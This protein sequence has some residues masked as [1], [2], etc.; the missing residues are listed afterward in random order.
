ME[1]K[2]V[3]V[4]MSG[5]VDSSVAVAVLKE[6]G[7]DVSGVFMQGWTNPNFECNWLSER[8]DA[9]RVAAVL[10]IPFRVLDYSREYYERVVSYLISEYKTGRTPNPDVMCNREIKFGLFYKWA[11]EQGA[12]YVAT[13]HYVRRDGEKLFIAKD[14]NKDQSYFLWTLTPEI[15]S[16]TLFPI[17]E[18]TKPKVRALARKYGL[19]TAEKKDSQGICFVGEGNIA[20]F[21]KDH[22]HATRGLIETAS[23]R[24]VGEHDG[25]EFYTIGQ[26]HGIGARGKNMQ[27][28][29]LV[30]AAEH[31]K[32]TLYKN[33]LHF[34][35]TNWL[36]PTP[37]VGHL[38]C[39]ARIRYR[40]PLQKC[41]VF[42]EQKVVF[43]EPQRAVTPG[44][45]VVFYKDGELLGGGV[46]S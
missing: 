3:F 39:E 24:V 4:A 2:K 35:N 46:I 18:Y 13:G 22:I 30:V 43:E 28:A 33:E 32:S 42:S 31:E 12:D 25:V 23:G 38:E 10:G 15:I 5:G 21:L 6:H 34:N 26:R 20:H 37:S 9:A 36:C 19:P 41:T 16:H 7:Y 29:T 27:T 44:Q 40:Q 11:M 45:S 8:Q 1:R 14:S 17:G